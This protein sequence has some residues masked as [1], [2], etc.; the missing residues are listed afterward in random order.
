MAATTSAA[1]T[2]ID[3]I[4]IYSEIGRGAFSVVYKGRLKQSITFVALKAVE[5]A[6]EDA[7]RRLMAAESPW[8]LAETVAWPCERET[9]E[10]RQK[11]AA[12]RMQPAD[13]LAV[14]DAFLS[15][16]LAATFLE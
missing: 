13:T 9:A 14:V 15:G 2:S 1:T 3:D 8:P 7:M 4:K 6:A 16:S 5:R 11:A 12:Q 10:W